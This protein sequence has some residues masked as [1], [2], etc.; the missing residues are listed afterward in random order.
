MKNQ[1]IE[2][3]R[4][5]SEVEKFAR[6]TCRHD[7]ALSVVQWLKDPSK[8]S[9]LQQPLEKLWDKHLEEK[10]VHDEAVDLQPTLDRIHDHISMQWEQPDPGFQKKLRIYKILLRVAAVLFVPL[11]ITTSLY[12][13][14][15]TRTSATKDQYTELTVSY[16][17]KLHTVLPDGTTV[18]INSGSKLEYPQTFSKKNRSVKLS[19]E[20]YFDVTLNRQHPF[21]VETEA[22]NIKVL[23]TRFNVTAYPGEETIS[24][25]LEEGSVAIETGGKKSSSLCLLEPNEQMVFQKE[26]RT[27]QKRT[28]QTDLFT[29]WKDGKLVF[30]NSSLNYMINQLER[31]FNT[32]I[33]IT[34][35]GGLPQTPFTMTIEDETL[36]QVLKYLSVASGIT[37][38]VVP[39]QRMESGEISRRRYIITN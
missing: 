31:W 26:N 24:A 8:K 3:R 14:E 1:N 17:S 9:S 32:D 5:S 28:V 39:A 34:N 29:S 16:G 11:L 13:H 30:R 37:Y 4:T 36:E 6:G 20:A 19:G 2:T 12:I 27:F 18:W 23:G 33:E 25:T 38:D 21:V 10:G 35:E 22:I 7:E 15:Q